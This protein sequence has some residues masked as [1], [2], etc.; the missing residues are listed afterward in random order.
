MKNLFLSLFYCLLSII[1]FSQNTNQS[2]KILSSLSKPQLED[3]NREA[4]R[5][6]EAFGKYISHISNAELPLE[7]RQEAALLAL[8]LFINK[9]VIIQDSVFCS[10]QFSIESYIDYLL[11]NAK[12]DIKIEWNDLFPHQQFSSDKAIKKVEIEQVVKYYQNYLM[13]KIE[14]SNKIIENHFRIEYKLI[15]NQSTRLIEIKLGNIFYKT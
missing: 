2:N 11:T 10:R 14:K 1:V 7:T 12:T 3:Y 5:I 13:H 4:E 6:T 15:Y 8:D 9:E